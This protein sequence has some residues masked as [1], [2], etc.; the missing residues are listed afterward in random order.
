MI[1]NSWGMYIKIIEH[2]T[3]IIVPVFTSFIGHK[4]F[5]FRRAI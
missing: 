4:Y 5:S 3:E 2:I 1:L